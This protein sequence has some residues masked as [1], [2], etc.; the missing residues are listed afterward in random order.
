MDPTSSYDTEIRYGMAATVELPY[1]EAV[2]LTRDALAAEGFGVLTE[3]DVR[4]TLRT[5]LDVEFRPYVIL[6]ACNPPLAHQAL[7]AEPD[8][9]LLLPC[10][11]V[12]QATDQEGR[13][14]VAILDPEAAL[15]LADNEAVRPLAR[16]VRTR[17]E[18]VL[19]A[20]VR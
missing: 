9:G 14:R 10:N 20:V 18:R 7:T 4:A 5:K 15:S 17:L 6:G 11:V 16:E 13:S 1:E 8:I 12:V 2:A 3:I 19:A